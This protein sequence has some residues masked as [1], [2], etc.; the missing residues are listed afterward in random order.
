MATKNASGHDNDTHL[1]G[2]L[3]VPVTS[4][5]NMSSRAGDANSV[6]Q[7]RDSSGGSSNRQFCA[8]HCVPNVILIT[9]EVLTIFIPNI[10]GNGVSH[11]LQMRVQRDSGI[12]L[13]SP[14]RTW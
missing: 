5:Q 1:L 3:C 10:L 12:R 11:L 7:R 4:P 13:R 6:A 8:A 2:G 9:L 14:A